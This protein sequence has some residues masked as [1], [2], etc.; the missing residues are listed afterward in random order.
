MKD[1]QTVIANGYRACKKYLAINFEYYQKTIQFE[2]LR[3]DI[4]NEMLDL[5]AKN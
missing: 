5:K 1:M 4:K 2:G 3:N